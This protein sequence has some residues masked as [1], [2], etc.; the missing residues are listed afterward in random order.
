MLNYVGSN[1]NIYRQLS[2]WL[3]FGNKVDFPSLPSENPAIELVF[4]Q[5]NPKPPGSPPPWQCG[6]LAKTVKML[7]A[8]H[9]LRTTLVWKGAFAFWYRQRNG[10]FRWITIV[11]MCLMVSRVST[12]LD[13]L[14]N[15]EKSGNSRE[16][17][18]KNARSQG[19]YLIHNYK[20]TVQFLF[21]QWPRPSM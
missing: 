16:L 19:I 20:N 17:C 11:L 14:D 10:K 18:E 15:L 3:L 6:G 2:T 9:L 12:N 7:Q 13:I 21:Y 5:W 1:A 4:H 8:S